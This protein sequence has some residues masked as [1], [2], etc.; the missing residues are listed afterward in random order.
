MKC[1]GFDDS[2]FRGSCTCVHQS[3]RAVDIG[4]ADWSSLDK[5]FAG[6]KT[7]RMLL[8]QPQADR[9]FSLVGCFEQQYPLKNRGAV[10]QFQFLLTQPFPIFD[11]HFHDPEAFPFHSVVQFNFN[12]ESF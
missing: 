4:S 6:G 7:M 8:I 2:W 12:V 5:N 11:R 3:A 9:C 10:A 1:V